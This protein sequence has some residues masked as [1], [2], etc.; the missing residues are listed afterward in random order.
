M[1]KPSKRQLELEQN[2]FSISGYNKISRNN[3]LREQG[4]ESETYYARNMIEA[5]LERLTV[6]LKSYIDKALKG[7]AGVKAL[8]AV[9]LNQFPDLDVVSFI[10]FKVIID[11]TSLEKT[12]TSIALNIGKMLEDEMRYTIFEQQDPK[13]FKAIKHH[14]RDTNHA[15]Y[16][17]NMVRSHMNKKGIEFQTWSKENK[18]RVG[19]KLIE[20]VIIHVGMIKLINKRVGKTTVSTVIFTEVADKWIKKGRANR[21]AAYPLYLPCFDKPKPYTTIFNGGYYTDRLKTCAVKTTNPESLQALQEEDLTV[22]LKALTLASHTAWT[23][24]KFVFDILVYCWEEGIEVGGLINKEPLELPTK[25]DSWDDKEKTKAWRYQASLIHDTN[26]ANKVKRFQILS[27]IDTAKKF[28]GEKFF[29][30]FQ[31][32]FCGRMYPLTAHFHPQGTDIAR[33]LHIFHEGAEI[34]TKR[35]LDWLAIAGANAYGLHGLNKASYEERLE[36]AYIEGSDFAEQ[37]A[38]DPIENLDIWG[39]AKE[40]FAFLGWCKEWY[41]FQNVGLNNGF[42]SRYCCCLDG[43]NNGY[44]H[45]AGLISS[46]NLASKVNLQYNKQPQDLYKDVLDKLLLLLESDTSEQATIWKRYSDKLTR[47]FIK[48]PVLMIPYNS[49]LFGIANYIERYFVNENIF[50]AKNFKN[51]YYLASLIQEA[52]KNIC[53]ESYTVLKYLSKI[54][55][56]FNKENKIIKWH[57]P[58]GFLVQQKYY[59]NHTKIVRTKL[60][61]S[62]MRLHI[63]VPNLLEVD[64]RKQAQGFPSNYIHSFDAAHLQLSLLKANQKGLHQFCIIHDCFGSPASQL[65]DF[66]HCVKQAFF[67]IYSDNNLDYLHH[68]SAEQLSDSKDLPSA[69]RMGDFDITDVLTAPYIFT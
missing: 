16:K 60:S 53:P 1:T 65:D 5:G 20:L 29:H 12:T 54:A 45:I 23:V 49:T 13:F 19:I 33:S 11:N 15:N 36:W 67:D 61:N 64:K 55:S 37:V 6:E 7:K 30:V 3:K 44:Q 28:V 50:I 25:P 57:T 34:K 63:G 18:L 38:L 40:P 39:K 46:T 10:A 4:R 35:D 21:I 59:M 48:K 58:S 66:I 69:L 41:D 8:A 22:S 62:S 26:H 51:N 56:C 24:N 31:M 52:V 27:I 32:D 17:K 42:I 47:K 2:I 14:T 43:T 9:Y 68:Q